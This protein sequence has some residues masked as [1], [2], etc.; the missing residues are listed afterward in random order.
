MLFAT[1][2]LARRIEQAEC[3]LTM[4]AARIAARRRSDVMIGP[5]AGGAAVF[6][7][8]GEP[9]N[10]AIGLGFGPPLDVQALEEIERAFE[11]RQTP[12]QVELAT[13][14]DSGLAVQLARRGYYLTNFENVLGLELTTEFL[15]QAERRLAAAAENGLAVE[16]APELS[17][18]IDAVITGFEHPD[19]FDGPASHESFPRGLLE[20]VYR[21]QKDAP[22]FRQYL[23][24][25]TGEVAGGGAMR[26]DEGVAQLC[27]AATLPPHRRRGVQS[28]LLQARLL[29]AARSGCD[30]AVVTTQPGSKSQEN[31]QRVGFVLLYSRAILIREIRSGRI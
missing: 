27:G 19:V 30:L 21:D 31:V 3:R 25:R 10:K 22:G 17:V 14:A 8:P 6:T 23:A 20:R 1:A 29:D 16:T 28:T 18:W 13:L 9:Y 26:V 2:S 24:R 11:E 7:G 12:L 15:E 5:I 4:D